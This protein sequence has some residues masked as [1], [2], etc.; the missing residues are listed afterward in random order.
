MSPPSSRR[1]ARTPG[2]NARGRTAPSPV[3]AAGARGIAPCRAV[4]NHG[5]VV[6]GKGEAMHKSR[7]NVVAPEEIIRKHGAEI[8]RLWVAAEDYRDD[9]RISND[10]LDRR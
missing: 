8:L 2:S 1:R 6:A 10:I 4:L 5:V 9:I 3:A 7:G